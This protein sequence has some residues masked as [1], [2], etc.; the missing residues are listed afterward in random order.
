MKN[1]KYGYYIDR[2]NLK[3]KIDSNYRAL[4]N[5]FDRGPRVSDLRNNL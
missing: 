4:R 2:V 1:D 3:N 5:L